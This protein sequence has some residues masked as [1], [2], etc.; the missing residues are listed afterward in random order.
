MAVTTTEHNFVPMPQTNDV[1]LEDFNYI[2]FKF[3]DQDQTPSNWSTLAITASGGG[4]QINRKVGIS[5]FCVEDF[6]QFKSGM[7]FDYDF[8]YD[9]I[10]V[11]NTFDYT[12]TILY[13]VD[14][15]ESRA[16]NSDRSDMLV[17][18][19]RR[20]NGQSGARIG[21]SSKYG[22]YLDVYFQ[23]YRRRFQGGTYTDEAISQTV[24]YSRIYKENE[25]DVNDSHTCLEFFYL[26]E[27]T[28]DY[29]LIGL[30][31][32]SI[33]DIPEFWGEPSFFLGISTSCSVSGE[34]Y[35]QYYTLWSP[36][37]DQFALWIKGD[38]MGRVADPYYGDG[39]DVG[40]YG[41]GKPTH[42]FSSDKIVRSNLPSS[43]ALTPGFLNAYQI[44]SNTLQHLGEALFPPIDENEFTDVAKSL[45]QFVLSQQNEKMLDFVVDCHIVPCAVTV[46]SS[47]NITVGGKT[48]ESI[49]GTLTAPKITNVYSTKSCGT[50]NIGEAF[51]NF[52]DYTVRCK[53]YL[54]FYGYVEI[55]PEYWNGGSIS[56]EYAFNVLDGTF[57]AFVSGK[58]NHSNLNSMIGQYSGCAITHIPV[59]G[60]DYSQIASGLISTGVAIAGTAGSIASTMATGGATAPIAVGSM[61]NL[62]SNI[63]NVMNSKPSLAGG[64]GTNSSSA[65]MMHKK[66]YLIIEYPTPQFSTRYPKEMGLPLNVAGTLG[67][68]GGMT[69]AENPVLD[70]IP[71]TEREKE[72]IRNALKTGL[73]F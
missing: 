47:S 53:L 64:G 18:K 34:G 12:S 71:C 20:T 19:A 22:T 41:E 58:A 66:P 50:L 7:E 67:Q 9:N 26:D 42:D 35:Y 37:P 61:A 17:I 10:Q 27:A 56:V 72:R 8:A 43:T 49:H 15:P 65:M 44:S 70:G 23:P 4:E 59:R 6:A 54:P 11:Q 52:L 25:F 62:G 5:G 2:E 3:P 68:F 32:W 51:G 29:I 28:N 45:Y 31:D 36:D 24:L 48:L 30:F 38:P 69:I 16:V 60:E 13:A 1:G 14:Y 63:Y 40:G 57:V 21:A 55:P 33:F 39:S 73:I 46:S